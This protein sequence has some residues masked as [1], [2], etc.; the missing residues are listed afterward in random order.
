VRSGSIDRSGFAP[1]VWTRRILLP[2]GLT[3]PGVF[4]ADAPS[5]PLL[6]RLRRQYTRVVDD[7]ALFRMAREKHRILAGGEVAGCSEILV[8]FRAHPP[9]GSPETRLGINFSV[10]RPALRFPSARRCKK[11]LHPLAQT[12]VLTG[13]ATDH[14][15]RPNYTAAGAG[16]RRPGNAAYNYP[17]PAVLSSFVSKFTRCA[18]KVAIW[19]A[20]A[21]CCVLPS[22]L[23]RER[24][25]LHGTA[26]RGQT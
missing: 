5:S 14:F 8:H 12:L 2:Y 23:H 1:G 18:N 3:R 6:C 22:L 25:A 4:R 7:L 24:R 15:N 11:R 9:A 26:D 19:R 20:T 16:P 21:V 13:H 17:R 10:A